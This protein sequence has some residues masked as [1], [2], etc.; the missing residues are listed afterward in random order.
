MADPSSPPALLPLFPIRGC[1][2]LPGEA[3]PLNVFEPRY[4]N[5]LDDCRSA[6]GW[7]GIIQPADGGARENP[8][9]EPVGCAGRLASFQET[10]D[11]RYLIVLQGVQ[12]FELEGESD[13]PRPYRLGKAEYARFA[14]DER[15]EREDVRV[16]PG[17]IALMKRYFDHAG[18]Q[19]DWDSLERAPIGM[20][21]DKVAMAAPFAP[22]AK[23][24][25]LEA[26]DCAA[27]IRVLGELVEEAL[28]PTG[29]TGAV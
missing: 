15:A 21:A 25:L 13:E 18:L 6:D 26:K 16:E 23:Q 29:R 4:L 8:E 3:L 17:F 7:L 24:A 22:P 28:N 1:I 27:R 10:E 11:G 19:A 2:L 20:I 12:R 5:M 14:D 9:L